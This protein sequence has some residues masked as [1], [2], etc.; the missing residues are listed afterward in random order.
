MVLSPSEY[1]CLPMCCT[2]YLYRVY[3]RIHV[4]S[5]ARLTLERMS[6]DSKT[7]D[8]KRSYFP[9]SWSILLS[10]DAHV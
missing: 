9:K 5:H 1:R 7:P 2:A 8:S 3:S 6:G 10:K 4:L